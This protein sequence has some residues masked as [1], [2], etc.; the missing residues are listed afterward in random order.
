MP[1]SGKSPGPV[2]GIDPGRSKVGFALVEADGAVVSAGIVTIAELPARLAALLA[3]F[4]AVA[5]LALGGGTNAGALAEQ[6]AGLGRPIVV[7]D[8][9]ETTRRARELYF[10]EHPPRGWRRLIPIGLQVPGRPVDDYAAI[11]IAQRFLGR[12]SGR[13]PQR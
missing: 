2:L 6:M 12:E 5:V 9:F 3:D 4:P 7:I 10:R 8:E 11:L 1:S 13:E